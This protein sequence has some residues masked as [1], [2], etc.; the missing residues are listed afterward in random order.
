MYLK[1]STPS[2]KKADETAKKI[3]K[4]LKPYKNK[5][6]TITTDNGF[7]FA[8]HKKVSKSLKCDYYFCHPYSSWERG[9]NENING[10]IRQFIPKGNSFDK[11]TKK[12]IQ[13]IEDKLNHRPRK[14][15]NWKTPYEV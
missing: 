10:L 14:S 2:S 11:L 6:H 9:L 4:M 1:I 7:E 3:I 12:D 5:I 15:L 8:D 13:R